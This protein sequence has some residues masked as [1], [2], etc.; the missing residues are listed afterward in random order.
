MR[1]ATKKP[2]T[3]QV[4]I[5]GG[6]HKR[7]LLSFLDIDGLRPTPDRLRET[8]F[9]WLMSDMLDATVLDVCAGSGVLGFEA[10]S[11]GAK[12]VV[13]IEPSKQ[14]GELSKNAKILNCT[15]QLHLINTTAQNALPT[16]NTPFD[17]IFLDP[18]YDLNLWQSLLDLIIMHGLYHDDTLIYS[19]SNR[20]LTEVFTTPIELIK[21][22][23]IGQ[24]HAGIFRLDPT[25]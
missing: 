3:N 1:N 25:P 12:S 23:K 6:M 20:P 5:I 9:N 10:L 19:E 21:S 4:R 17:V 7:R 16:L 11:R 13:M 8:L 2:T 14:A 22:T 24:I 15:A 18:P